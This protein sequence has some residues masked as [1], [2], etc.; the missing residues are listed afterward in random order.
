[1]ADPR[2]SILGP[3]E[4]TS[5]G[6]ALDLGPRKQRLVL[7]SLLVAAPAVVS[8]GALIDRVWGE[9]PP[10]SAGHALQVY[11]SKLRKLLEPDRAA[12]G[13]GRV[14]ITRE[15]GYC[16]AVAPGALDAAVFER[17]VVG[18]RV[19]DVAARAGQLD[20]ALALWRGSPLADV[21]DQPW[22]V[23][24][25][26]RLSG[27]R[28]AAM[29]DRFDALLTLGRHRDVVHE[30]ESA[31]REHPLRERFWAQ[32]VLALY[33]SG[34]QADALRALAEVR[35]R[36][37]EE[38]G[39]A[40]GPELCE[41]ESSVL[42]QDARL[43]L[44]QPDPPQKPLVVAGAD[45]GS[46]DAVGAG[47][48]P[49]ARDLAA[50][51][52]PSEVPATS[53]EAPPGPNDELRV[54]TALF[55]D[56]VGSTPLG[57]ELP[58]D[59]FKLVIDGA[60]ERMVAACEDFGGRVVNVAGDGVLALFGA[61]VAHE[62]DAERAVLAGRQLVSSVSAYGADVAAGWGVEP[63][64]SRVG[65]NTGPVVTGWTGA[66]SHV[67]FSALGDAVNTAARL[68]SAAERNSVL[69]AEATSA[70][71]GPTFSWSDAR[72]LTLK[73][74]AEPITA[75]EAL[76]G[77]PGGRRPRGIGG[78]R[79]PLRARD[80]ELS[81]ALAAID[82]VIGGRG[83]VL[84][85]TGSA[86]L[87]KSRLLAEIQQVFEARHDP[88]RPGLW[89]QGSCPSYGH[90]RPLW[91]IRE[92]VGA[93]VGGS[94]DQPPLRRRVALRSRLDALLDDSARAYAALANVLGIDDAADADESTDDG[95]TLHEQVCSVLSRVAHDQPVVVAVDDV[96]WA[97][98]E[99]LRLLERLAGQ[100][101]H[102][103]ILLVLASRPE[104]DHGS[105]DLRER[106]LREAPHRSTH[107]E[108]TVLDRTSAASMLAEVVGADTLP[109]RVRDEVLTLAEG[110]PFYLEELVR[111]LISDGVLVRRN[112]ALAYVGGGSARLPDGVGQVVVSRLDRIGTEARSV[113]T[114]ASVLGR[115]FTADL[116]SGL[117]GDAVDE[118]TLEDL[119]IDLQRHQLIREVRRWPTATYE[120]EH[121]LIREA[122]YDTLVVTRRR[123]LHA[124][125]AVVLT[126]RASTDAV[127]AGEVAHHW[128]LAG[129]DQ[130]A[131]EAYRE[132][133]V[134]AEGRGILTSAASLYTQALEAAARLG[135]E[136]VTP[137]V[138]APLSVARWTAGLRGGDLEDARRGLEMAILQAREMGDPAT[139]ALALRAL[140]HSGVA[141]DIGRT[142]GEAFLEALD[143]A[144]RSGDAEI[145]VQV[146]APLAIDEANDLAL[147]RARERVMEALAVVDTSPPDVRVYALDARKLVALYLGELDELEHVFDELLPMVE[148]PELA[149][150]RRHALVEHA[151]L[152]EAVGDMATARAR[153][154]EALAFSD[155]VSGS[156]GREVFLA[157]LCRVL[158]ASG[159]YGPALAAGTEACGLARASG[160][161][162]VPWAAAE[163]G[164]LLI[165][166]GC[167]EE[168]VE[169]LGRALRANP[170]MRSQEVRCA[171]LLGLAGLR[172][173]D[174][175]AESRGAEAAD[176]M[177]A[178]MTCPP[179][180]TYLYGADA[181]LSLAEV[182]SARGHHD[183][184]TRLADNVAQAASTS[185]W[186][187]PEARARLVLGLDAARR[188]EGTV[189]LSHLRRSIALAGD[190]VPGT[191]WRAHAAMGRMT[192]DASAERTARSI[193]LQLAR[194]LDEPRRGFF[195][196]AFD[197]EVD[198]MG[199]T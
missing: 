46:P 74:K 183:A 65:V 95:R 6:R 11:V 147:Q 89:L 131:F 60:L 80:A 104:R 85:V 102:A 161:W 139:E 114:A 130:R 49:D 116:L 81:K 43:A 172:A 33:R 23:N 141:V 99:S 8:T 181:Q 48:S 134:E 124:R 176:E 198:A 61:P 158:R 125:A 182:R 195:E 197:A 191:A 167:H 97:D 169:C 165:E 50:V 68:E 92:I 98:A 171:A 140:A 107:V 115:A 83:G 106:V 133:A 103:A 76:R 30:I 110:N 20:E 128:E 75:F 19:G 152:A 24:A 40:P 29:E 45:H 113:L 105:W 136:R 177:L 160:R 2:F 94:P 193:H 157:V 15:P 188:G 70:Q 39:V 135:P 59:E 86:G 120:F 162:W 57:E 38:L 17:M 187:E 73:G 90:S 47:A 55:A 184:A 155:T 137:A 174:A 111:T 66:G 148:R 63:L 77:E 186:L 69:V 12:R 109:D 132:A 138:L 72:S 13:S 127:D 159:R 194:A 149:W 56:L 151:A 168:A 32:L 199:L 79:T 84:L 143:V 179:G 170:P 178:T 10:A 16:L 154:E 163:H 62:D 9:H 3:I 112:G 25:A 145:T 54:V 190:V 189:A 27:L 150:M 34:R 53:D 196:S 144:R 28:L 117:L 123:H 44:I 42:R 164:A 173:G 52:S 175:Q 101:E 185:G 31:A 7:A 82:E 71:L 14:L 58:P 118:A 22:A 88:E 122:A 91:P 21:A 78:R 153:A 51:P 180:M 67:Q 4:V 37:L 1:M 119:L 93:W 121:A 142:R 108:L 126:G 166:L 192:G 41:L 5:D 87:G 100:V 64:A 156:V 146:L 35:Q 129:D 18:S 26:T 36:L 96:H